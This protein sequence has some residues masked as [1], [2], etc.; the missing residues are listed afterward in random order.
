MTAGNARPKGRGQGAWVLAAIVALALAVRCLWAFGLLGGRVVWGDEP[1]YLWLGH[2]VLTTGFYSFTG[3]WDVHHTPLYPLAAGLLSLLTGD[4][5]LASDLCYVLFG[6]LLVLPV[7]GLGRELY[8][9]AAGWAAALT[10]AMLPSLVVA[11]LLW[12]TMTEPIYLFCVASGMWALWAGWRRSRWAGFALAGVCFALA[13]L[14]RPEAIWY[15]IALGGAL[16]LVQ[17]L[18]R[19]RRLAPWGRLLVL[20]LAF[21]ATVFPYLAYV[22]VHT[23]QWMVSEKVGLAY[24]HG[25]ALGHRDYAAFDRVAWGLDSAGTEVWFFSPESYTLSLSEQILAD[26]P[27]FLNLLRLN[28]LRFVQT[29]GITRFFP[30]LLFP[31]LFLGFFRQPWD[32]R[33]LEGE[34]YLWLSSVSV[35]SFLIFQVLDRYLTPLLILLAL[36]LGK[37]LVEWGDWA[38]ATLHQTARRASGGWLR[39]ARWG[40]VVLVAAGL[41]ALWGPV[42]TDLQVPNSW[43]PA[44]RAVGEW[45]AE[46]AGPDDAIMSRYPAVAFHAGRRWVA[47]AN[48]SLDELRRYAQD[49]GVDYLVVDARELGLRPQFAPLVEGTT[50]PPWLELA[51]VQEEGDERIVIYRLTGGA[52]D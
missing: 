22:R 24:A 11:P 8:G 44:H 47:T 1:F 18:R 6:T 52:G 48:A 9:R 43:R 16:G 20:G 42:Q 25:F 2:N 15:P 19:E 38:V 12:G 51:A 46:V 4:L 35:F 28:V 29:L 7:Y 39:A 5:K 3:Y 17:L 36:W 49:K 30:A 10:V 32:R 41:A 31:L 50:P 23:G 33:R 37:G 34:L 45:L 26:V 40:L 21:L 14:A 27:G 13:Y